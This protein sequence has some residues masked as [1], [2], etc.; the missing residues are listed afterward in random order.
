MARSTIVNCQWQEQP[1]S[2]V[3]VTKDEMDPWDNMSA[4]FM[5]VEEMRRQYWAEAI[6][7]GLDEVQASEYASLM[8]N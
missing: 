5:F 1:A 7:A 3:T 4:D 8:T 2:P 6:G